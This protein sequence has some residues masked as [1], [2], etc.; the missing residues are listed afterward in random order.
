VKKALRDRVAIAVVDQRGRRIQH[1]ATL[2]GTREGLAEIVQPDMQAEL[3]VRRAGRA[4]HGAPCAFARTGVP[5]DL[6][7]QPRGR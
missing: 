6:L 7:Q 5:D 1:A 2:S 3:R 4:G